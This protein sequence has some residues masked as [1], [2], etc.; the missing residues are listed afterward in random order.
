MRKKRNY[1][2]NLNETLGIKFLL[3]EV[4]ITHEKYKKSGSCFGTDLFKRQANY[5]D[6]ATFNGRFL[7]KEKG[8]ERNKLRVG[9]AEMT[10][11]DGS[12]VLPIFRS[13]INKKGR[14]RN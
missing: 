7:S 8:T 13:T 2:W 6:L 3:T 11:R 1:K 12:Y 10:I 4:K 9:L 5:I 14:K